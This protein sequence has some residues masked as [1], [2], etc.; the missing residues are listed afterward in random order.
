MRLGAYE[1][2]G[3][4]GAGGMGEV[5][6]ARD[7]RLDRSVAIKVLPSEYALDAAL[8]LRFERE[9]RTISSLSHPNICT[10]FDVGSTGE[11]S[12]LVMEYLEGE[13]LADRLAKGPLP[14]D[15]VLKLGVEVASA[16]ESAHRQGITHRDV[17][18]GNIMLTRTGAK[19]LDFG[20]AKPR[21]TPVDPLT[22][23]ST[24][25]K[26][27]T[28]QG[29]IIGTFQ[30]MA[31]EQLEGREADAR[32]DIFALGAVLYEAATGQ[33]AFEGKSR[34]SLIA[35]IL[36]HEPP[37]ISLARPL[38]PLSLD[39]VV[40]ACLRKD[41]ADRIQT[42]HDLALDLSW[43]RESSSTGEAAITP[44]GGRRRWLMPA[45]AAVL[46]VAAVTF[47]GLYLRSRSK[48][49][50]RAVFSILPTT[51]S[52]IAESVAVAPDGRSI[53]YAANVGDERLL[54]IR[55]FDDP[56]PRS[57][58]GTDGAAWPFWSPDGQWIGFFGQSKLKR[59]NV[60]SG[61]V[62]NIT[63]GHYGVGA[64]WSPDG[65][66]VFSRRFNEGLFQVRAAG[67][68]ATPVTKLDSARKESLHGW[69]QFLSDGR[70]FLFVNRT[71]ADERNRI[72]AASLD[73]G[74]PKLLTNAD[75][76]AGFHDGRL[77]F[78]R[79]NVLY[80]QDL[81]EDALELQGDPVEVAR[82]VGYF[83][84]WSSSGASVGASGVVAYLP[85]IV[86]HADVRLYDRRGTVVRTILSDRGVYD[87]VMSPD[88]LRMAM[89]VW[90]VR[91]GAADVWI[92]DL[93]RGV[94]TRITG[95][96]AN[97]NEPAWS[98]DG[99]RVV[100]VSDRGGMFD[101][102]VQAVDDPAPPQV[103]WKSD[104]DKENPVWMPD[105]KSIVTG[106]D[107]PETGGDIFESSLTGET[108]P[109]VTTEAGE[110]E[111]AVSPDGRMLAFTARRGTNEVHVM[112]IRGG[113]M[114]QVSA[115]G[116]EYPAWS[117]D[118]S[119]LYYVG[120]GRMLMAVRMVPSPGLPQPLFELPRTVRTRPYTVTPD[121][122]FLI[123][124]VDREE[125]PAP[126]INVI[127]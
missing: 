39:R 36:D 71:V 110:D 48:P 14:I 107:D 55:S 91:K 80:S 82:H 32:T 4:I 13:S 10:L 56:Q 63:D 116:G 95:G 119:E 30:Y 24:E 16:L 54:W 102:Y 8:K 76:L 43:I 35:A 7:T 25:L 81:D 11:R 15:Q 115:N 64:A 58:A 28:E 66:I 88:R 9:A 1:I 121:G 84:A 96:L 75:S 59:V 42:A 114:T 120:R 17:K 78:V 6:R 12:Y 125:S 93:A 52:A 87:A 60:A 20:L 33:R 38:A 50:E 34:A 123:A 101:L 77:F 2:L 41:P 97:N 112:P 47:A 40:R 74:A 122:N 92:V 37:P 29:T 18:P 79:E 127:R 45:L 26:P 19:L 111:P 68:D 67:G 3:P 69:P 106:K 70:R 44:R 49:A 94:R 57:L 99:T 109:L 83:E 126:H 90:D 85:A 98:P 117:P 72:A 27:I 21:A 103:V 104:H 31:P 100:Y 62:Q 113:R 105:G 61:S 118:G 22:V 108:R 51:G 46:A 23:M 124:A 53:A 65:T 86:P 73:G 5:Y 89:S